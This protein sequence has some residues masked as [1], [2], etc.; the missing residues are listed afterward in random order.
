MSKATKALRVSL[1][2]FTGDQKIAGCGQ[3][4]RLADIKSIAVR[5]FH[6]FSVEP[7]FSGTDEWRFL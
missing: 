7:I 4:I 2:D 5:N 3:D 6:S 1:S